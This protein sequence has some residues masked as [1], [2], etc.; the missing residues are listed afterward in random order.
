[1]EN[2]ELKAFI[3]ILKNISLIEYAQAYYPGQSIIY[4]LACI[5]LVETYLFFLPTLG[6]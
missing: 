2:L 1:M 3:N 6:K 5:L 4:F